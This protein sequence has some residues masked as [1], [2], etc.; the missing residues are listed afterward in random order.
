MKQIQ[1]LFIKKN[2]QV[3]IKENGSFYSFKPG[4]YRKTFVNKKRILGEI[5]E[6]QIDYSFK[7]IYILHSINLEEIFI[8]TSEYQYIVRTIKRDNK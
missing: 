7:E 4:I 2:S 8:S 3:T 5:N 6:D 1:N